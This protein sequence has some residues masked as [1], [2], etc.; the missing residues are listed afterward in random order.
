MGDFQICIPPIK[1]QG[2]KTKIVPL[3]Y[4]VIPK[5]FDGVWIEPFI[6]SGVVGFNIAKERAIFADLNPHIISFYNALKNRYIDEKSVRDFLEQEGAKLLESEDYYYEVRE[7]FNTTFE[8][9][10]FLFLNRA[11]FNG[12]VRFNKK[13]KFNT[14]FCKKKDRFSKAYITKIVNQIKCVQ[15]LI[16]NNDWSFVCKDF[17]QTISLAK[18]GDILYCD[19]PYIGRNSNY[20]DN[21]SEKNEELLYQLLRESRA[22]FVL[23]TWWKDRYRE[24]IFFR[25][26]RQ[27]F[28]TISREHFYY[29]GA[30]EYNRNSITEVLVL[31]YKFNL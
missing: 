4:Q 25:K 15:N 3:I 18:E 27:N 13:G 11:C 24:N 19:P 12:V 17:S 30:K 23:S 29:V 2:I 7:R 14:P 21:W 1:I 22:K 28:Y 20:Y 8:P 6:G 9:L 10:D 26:W 5:D 31:N 16:C